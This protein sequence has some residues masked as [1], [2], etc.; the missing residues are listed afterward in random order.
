LTTMITPG[1]S[2]AQIEIPQALERCRAR[3]SHLRLHY[4]WPFEPE[5]VATLLLEQLAS[6]ERHDLP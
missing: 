1:G 3:F 2:H 4:A 6:S 5:L